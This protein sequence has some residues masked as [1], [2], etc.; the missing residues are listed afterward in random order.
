MVIF[1]SRLSHDNMPGIDVSTGCRNCSDGKDE[2][3]RAG[4]IPPGVYPN[5][6]S[7]FMLATLKSFLLT[8]GKSQIFCN[9][10][11]HA[12]E[13]QLKLVSRRS[14]KAKVLKPFS[15]LNSRSLCPYA[16]PDESSVL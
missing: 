7:N 1:I 2:C 8:P 13:V 5:F 15:V 11:Y 4:D 16:S 9:R 10:F 12:H 3:S 6:S 14:E